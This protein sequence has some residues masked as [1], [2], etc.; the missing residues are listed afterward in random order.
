LLA[1][2]TYFIV[3]VIIHP[4]QCAANLAASGWLVVRLGRRLLARYTRQFIN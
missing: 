1:H 3:T 4:V 2:I